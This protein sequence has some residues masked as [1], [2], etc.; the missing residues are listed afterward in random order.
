MKESFCFNPVHYLLKSERK[1]DYEAPTVSRAA[2]KP[3]TAITQRDWN[4]L[5]DG[6]RNCLTQVLLPA[7]LTSGNIGA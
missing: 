7:S 5:P 4:G 3:Q 2:R 6:A 1:E